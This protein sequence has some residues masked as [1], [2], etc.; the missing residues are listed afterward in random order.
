[1]TS[2]DSYNFLFQDNI[3]EGTKH[4]YVAVGPQDDPIPQFESGINQTNANETTIPDPDDG[5]TLQLN[6]KLFLR[7]YSKEIALEAISYLEKRLCKLI[8]INYITKTVKD[9]K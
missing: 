9:V 3:I 5:N 2:C 1:M 4:N 6:V 8:N 7:E